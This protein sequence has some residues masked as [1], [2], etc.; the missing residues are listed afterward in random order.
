MELSSNVV[1]DSNDEKNFLHKLLLTNAQILKLRKTFGNG[2][3]ANIKLSKIELHKIRQSGGFLGRFLKP[4]L[5]TGLPLIENV[6]KPLTKS[7]LIPLGLTVTASATDAGVH[8]KIFRSGI[9]TLIISNEEINDIA[10]IVKYLDKSGLLIKGVS[11][12]IKNKEKE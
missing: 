6:L 4:L 9:T 1:V 8:K 12:T 2:S 10:K 11:K 7:I 3:S 5:K